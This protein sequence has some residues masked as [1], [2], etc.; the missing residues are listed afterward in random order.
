MTSTLSSTPT[1]VEEGRHPRRETQRWLGNAIAIEN[2]ETAN[3]NQTL[4]ARLGGAGGR[5]GTNG[6][7]GGSGLTPGASG[8]TNGVQSNDGQVPVSFTADPSCA[9]GSAIRV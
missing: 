9:N 3:G 6:G 4:P 2:P 7:G 8:M 1:V 5:A